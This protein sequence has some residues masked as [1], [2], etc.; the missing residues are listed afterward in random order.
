MRPSHLNTFLQHFLYGFCMQHGSILLT[1][2]RSSSSDKS[3]QTCCARKVALEYD[4]GNAVK[5]CSGFCHLQF[6]LR[7][8]A[9]YKRNQ[10]SWSKPLVIA[11]VSAA[12]V[13]TTQ[14][15]GLIGHCQFWAMSLWVARMI[16]QHANLGFW[17]IKN[18]AS[19]NIKTRRSSHLMG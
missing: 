13:D 4:S 1:V 7:S 9:Q 16:F 8:Q 11:M 2:W 10:V 3:A 12:R 5:V 6:G 14:H 19:E 17:A 18:E 15:I